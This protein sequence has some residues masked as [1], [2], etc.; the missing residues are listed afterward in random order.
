[1]PQNSFMISMFPHSEKSFTT[2]RCNLH[3]TSNREKERRR[4]REKERRRE[5]EKE[6]KREREKEIRRERE[7]ERRKERKSFLGC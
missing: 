3:Q 2:F 7:K 1:M 6:R 5:G 4:E